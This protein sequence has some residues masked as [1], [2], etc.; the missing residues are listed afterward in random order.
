MATGPEEKPSYAA[1]AHTLS[2]LRHTIGV[3]PNASKAPTRR[4]KSHMDSKME[5]R[6]KMSLVIVDSRGKK[7]R[8]IV[9]ITSMPRLQD[10]FEDK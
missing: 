2:E 9:P 10:F 7:S 1:L 5:E 4:L 6:D 3:A 8:M